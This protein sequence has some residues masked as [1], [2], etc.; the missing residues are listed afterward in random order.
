MKKSC[1]PHGLCVYGLL[2]AVI[3]LERA[4]GAADPGREPLH[5]RIDRLIDAGRVGPAAT[6]TGDAE[7]LRGCG[8]T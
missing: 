2:F 3:L 6:V 5:C 8:S 7:F 4:A 1:L